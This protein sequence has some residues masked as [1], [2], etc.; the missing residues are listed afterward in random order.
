LLAS[1]ADNSAGS[2]LTIT[3]P[4]AAGLDSPS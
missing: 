2:E 3:S 1:G 4:G